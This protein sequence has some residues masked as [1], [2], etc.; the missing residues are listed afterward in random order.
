MSAP[1]N[2]G[3]E[4]ARLRDSMNQ[5]LSDSAAGMPQPEPMDN[6]D[7]IPPV[8]I[9]EN[10]DDVIVKVDLPGLNTDEIDLSISG[11]VLQITGERKQKTERQDENYHTIERDY[12][13][14]DRRINLPT[15][16]SV[17]NIKASYDN[18]VLT[19]TLP[20]PEEQKTEQFRVALE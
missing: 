9:L 4:L 18:G 5:I 7:W 16:V 14:F 1:R 19:V 17:D 13:R 8:D 12:G 3:E 10:R 11:G 15:S 20:K 2:F 6:V